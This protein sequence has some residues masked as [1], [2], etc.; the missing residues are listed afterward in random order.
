MHAH[1]KLPIDLPM[2][3]IASGV[4]LRTPAPRIDRSEGPSASTGSGRGV[5]TCCTL[6]QLR[7]TED[8]LRVKLRAKPPLDVQPPQRR[9]ESVEPPHQPSRCR[10]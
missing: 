10:R 2:I 5:P 1:V 6:R 7:A 8:S 3:R 4:R 9:P